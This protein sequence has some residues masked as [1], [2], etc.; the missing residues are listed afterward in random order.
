MSP[1]V[2]SA[3][4]RTDI[5]AFYAQWFMNRIE[6]GFCH[7]F[8]PFNQKRQE[9]SLRPEDCLAIIFWTRNPRPLLPFLPRLR[10]LG[11]R[12]AF[13]FTIT[14]YPKP[15]EANTPTVD[16][17]IDA[18]K[19]LSDLVS[20]E[21]VSWRYDPLIISNST[22]LAWHREQF[23]DLSQRLRGYTRRCFFSFVS[24]YGKTKRRLKSL[25]DQHDLLVIEPSLRLKDELLTALVPMARGA[26]MSLHT[27]CDDSLVREGIVKAHCIDSELVAALRPDLTVSLSPKPTRPGCGCYDSVDIGA[28]DTC[29]FGCS[30]CYATVNPEMARR[31]RRRHDPSQAALLPPQNRPAGKTP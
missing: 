1:K 28:Y 17:A 30:Y 8:N 21:F 14:G 18:F 23:G 20:P 22:P 15:I 12:F 2:I 9:V 27:C 13:H 31:N 25:H 26:K 7:W 4:R 19:R 11:Y 10:D 3:S 29:T 6:A 24:W 16:S 5:P